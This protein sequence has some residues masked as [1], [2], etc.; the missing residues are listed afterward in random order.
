LHRWALGSRATGSNIL[1]AARRNARTLRA[2]ERLAET[3][4]TPMS[5]L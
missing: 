4:E 2:Q 1:R 5:F 3:T